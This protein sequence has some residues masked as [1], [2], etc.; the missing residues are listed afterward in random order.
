[1][2]LLHLAV[3]Q[4]PSGKIL[5]LIGNGEDGKSMMGVLEKCALGSINVGNIEYTVFLEKEEFRKS[6]QF[7]ADKVAVRIQEASS[8]KHI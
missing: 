4:L 7:A 6:T 2:C 3:R 1:M 5:I 8:E